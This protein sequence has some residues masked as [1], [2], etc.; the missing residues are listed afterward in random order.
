M[1]R[2]AFRAPRHLRNDRYSQAYRDRLAEGWTFFL[3][4]LRIMAVPL[5]LMSGAS[6]RA[7]DS[8][9]CEFVQWCYNSSLSLGIATHGLLSVQH[10]FSLR[11]QLGE[12]WES[13]RTWK[14]EEPPSYRL[15]F[16]PYILQCVLLYFLGAGMRTVGRLRALYFGA[17]VV[18]RIGFFGLLRPEELL[19][20][21][22]QQVGLPTNLLLGGGRSMV[23]VLYR[24]KTRRYMGRRQFS[25]VSDL[26][27]VAW[28]EWFVQGL[29]ADQRLFPGSP[30]ELRGLL[31]EALAF[32]GLDGL[33]LSLAGLRTGGATYRFRVEQ[34]IGALQFQG[35]WRAPSTMHHYL[36][37][38][39]AAHLI[40]QLSAATETFLLSLQSRL[41]MVRAPPPQ[42]AVELIPWGRHR[43]AARDSC[44]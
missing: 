27:T 11:R 29:G 13:I 38:G 40:T 18:C 24:P 17:M 37:E 35:R 41:N 33:G 23:I 42:S 25:M 39:M 12:A 1:T 8:L 36:Q 16:S 14:V 43:D 21:T 20:L 31:K 2:P 15:P 32:L 34:N 19:T 3:R 5:S 10:R 28:T 6:G 30:S 9:M 7:A 44:S 4:F 22:V 26:E